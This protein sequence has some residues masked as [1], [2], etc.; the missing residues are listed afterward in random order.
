MT[1]FLV[2]A[3][4]RR[5]PGTPAP[6]AVEV[7]DARGLHRVAPERPETIGYEEWERLAVPVR[8]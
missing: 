2:A 4:V 6:R 5:A 7:R 8:R 3:A 1:P